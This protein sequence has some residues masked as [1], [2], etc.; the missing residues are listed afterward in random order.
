MTTLTE[1]HLHKYGFKKLPFGT[2]Y[3]GDFTILKRQAQK[4]P[5]DE[6]FI[7]SKDDDFFIVG[8]LEELEKL[9][10]VFEKKTLEVKNEGPNSWRGG[11]YDV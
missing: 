11:L 1:D 9:Y 10:L 7:L 3:L 8:T 4:P 6:A 5:Y 2:Y